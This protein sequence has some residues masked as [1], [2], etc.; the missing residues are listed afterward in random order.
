MTAPRSGR[1]LSILVSTTFLNLPKADIRDAP[2]IR[3]LVLGLHL[4]KP[5]MLVIYADIKNEVTR[6]KLTLIVLSHLTPRTSV[7][8]ATAQ[9]SSAFSAATISC[10]RRGHGRH[11]VSPVREFFKNKTRSAD[12]RNSFGS[13]V[14]VDLKSCFKASFAPSPTECFLG[15]TRSVGS[16]ALSCLMVMVVEV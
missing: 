5:S 16:D 14:F 4:S 9:P 10:S 1:C 6:S 13:S 11:T 2:G 12:F 3:S 7:I 8:A 15:P